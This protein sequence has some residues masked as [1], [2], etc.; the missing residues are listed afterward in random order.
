MMLLDKGRT[1]TALLALIGIGSVLNGL[2]MLA[3]PIIWY[4]R[5]PA[6]L[7]DFGMPNEHLVRD[8]GC[9]FLAVG[10]G[11]LWAVREPAHHRPL[12]ALASVFYGVHA[13]VH[14]WDTGTG[15]VDAWHWLIDLPLTYLPACLLLGMLF[16]R[17]SG[18]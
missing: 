2:W 13:L 1:G 12:V 16:W 17:P 9:G 8:A 4:A 6:A 5:I 7:A 11:L 10:I 18:R 3:T 14:V 15:V